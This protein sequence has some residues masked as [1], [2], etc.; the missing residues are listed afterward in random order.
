[1]LKVKSTDLYKSKEFNVDKHYGDSLS[2]KLNASYDIIEKKI[3]I[4][5]HYMQKFPLEDGEFDG[6]ESTEGFVFYLIGD[7]FYLKEIV[8][9]G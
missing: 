1:M 6:V 3:N 4:S 9:A 8:L 7:R 2:Y 5:M